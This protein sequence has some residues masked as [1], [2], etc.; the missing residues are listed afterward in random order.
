M[1]DPL[2]VFLRKCLRS[3]PGPSMFLSG[4]IKWIILSFPHRNS[5]IIFALGSWDDFWSLWYRI[6]TGPFFCFYTLWKWHCDVYLMF[7]TKC[8]NCCQVQ[9][10]KSKSWEPYWTGV[11]ISLKIENH[12][13]TRKNI[14]KFSIVQNLI[15]YWI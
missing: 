7:E 11:N 3:F 2:E 4:R 9:L 5:K 1:K 15:F 14:P 8:V 12:S 6:R 13:G 10:K